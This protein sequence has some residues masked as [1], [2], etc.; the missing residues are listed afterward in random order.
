MKAFNGV[1]SLFPTE[2]IC[3]RSIFF[4]I[5]SGHFG[6]FQ[7]NFNKS[8]KD[9]VMFDKSVKDAVMFNKSVKDAVMFDKRVCYP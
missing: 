7:A 6:L 2:F 5:N 1:L 3:M 9:A 8:V 4:W